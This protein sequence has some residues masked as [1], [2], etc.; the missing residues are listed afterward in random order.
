[1]KK[2][3]PEDEWFRREITPCILRAAERSKRAEYT[4]WAKYFVEMNDHLVN[5]VERKC[6][7]EK[8]NPRS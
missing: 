1:M 3:T 7:L 2:K 8:L 6:E 5:L 4:D